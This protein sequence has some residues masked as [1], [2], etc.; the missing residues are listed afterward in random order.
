MLVTEHGMGCLGFVASRIPKHA[1]HSS[2][3]TISLIHRSAS[4]LQH[5]CVAE[6]RAQ[7]WSHACKTAQ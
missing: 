5:K 3:L 1:A 4:A 6:V 2:A 7:A